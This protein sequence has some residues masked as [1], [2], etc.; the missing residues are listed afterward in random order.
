M[1]TITQVFSGFD[2][3]LL[4]ELQKVPLNLKCDRHEKTD[5][6]SSKLDLATLFFESVDPGLT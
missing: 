1:A 4:L 6:Y 3:T 5:N 2:S